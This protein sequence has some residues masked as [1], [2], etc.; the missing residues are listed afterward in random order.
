MDE[1]VFLIII[2][3]IVIVSVPIIIL[4]KISNIN[5]NID[6]LNKEINDLNKKLVDISNKAVTKDETKEILNTVK[7]IND[8]I[9]VSAPITQLAHLK[10]QS[11]PIDFLKSSK[12][13]KV[14][15]APT[16][17]SEITLDPIIEEIRVDKT[18]V[19]DMPV[20][21]IEL[22]E[23]KEKLEPL[24][25][26]AAFKRTEL[27]KKETIYTETPPPY[28]SQPKAAVQSTQKE[29]DGRNFIERILGE[30][31]LS[32][33]GIITLVLGIAFF[34]KYAIDQEWINEVGRVGIGLLTGGIL[35]GIAHKLK[36]KYHV[37]SSLLVGGGISTFYITITLAFREYELFS[38]T[39]AFAILI[40]I[41]VFSVIL[42]LL[43]DRKE[44]AI[45]SLLGG[46]ASPLMIST[47]TGNYIV[48]FS[49][50]LILNTGM[51][52]VSFRKKWPII[53]II[54]YVLTLIFFWSWILRSYE[55]QYFEVT[56]FAVLF[57]VQFYLL[58]LIDHFKQEKKITTYQAILILTNNLSLFLAWIYIFNEYPYDV[59]G[60][61]TISIAAVN[62]IVM[63][64]LFRKS[65]IDRN[66]IYLIIAVVMTFVSLAIPIQLQGY[67]ITMFWAAEAVLL[68]WLWQKSQIKVFQIGFLLVSALVIVSYIID[69]QRNYGDKDD[70]SI[71]LNSIFITGLVVIGGFVINS[72]L[73]KRE[74]KD[75][76]IKIHNIEFFSLD[77]VIYIFKALLIISVFIVPFIELNYQLER[78]TDTEYSSSFRYVS[79]A[80]YSFT[81]IIT[82]IFIHR[83]K[84]SS[85]MMYLTLLTFV[86]GA[87]SLIFSSLAT[88]LRF[89]VFCLNEYTASYF[90]VHLISLPAIVFAI[91]QIIKNIK[92]LPPQMFQAF[93]WATVIF[94][95]IILSVETDNFIILLLGHSENYSDILYDVHTFGYPIL[96]GVIAMILMIWG[97][98]QREV[99]LR[100][101]SLIFFGLII[102][103][104]YAYDV[105]H[106]SQA[107]RIISF[108]L[109]GV[110]L[111]LVSFLQQKIKIL[112][113]DEN[114]PEGINKEE[115]TIE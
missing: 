68:L 87:Y 23:T 19:E 91:Y 48:L 34:V 2:V 84:I 89:D 16:I 100:K 76:I 92:Q 113:K 43:Y 65:T 12:T 3:L 31:W 104:F 72:F 11:E 64:I 88:D 107:G 115:N 86:V 85:K 109:L 103:K 49:Y 111:L 98:K 39:I 63:L 35:I 71:A 36:S 10:E 41:T 30:N 110:I 29:D 101:I 106:M 80:V 56:L 37:F 9:Q 5:K 81:Y 40:M 83:E 55:A 21:A 1:I 82:V 61:I 97:L 20:K 25:P 38:Q 58:A 69:I 7:D 50:I 96:W 42:S 28:Y 4:V 33:V 46:F 17:T 45:F 70:L 15:D 24:R 14:E 18:T 62:A 52:L 74:D 54:S 59:R 78:F 27:D 105:W 102:L 53:G 67:V 94:S 112:V 93:C 26:V 73:L 99:L 8:K 66:L 77:T 51:L 6:Y 108:V 44:L 57:F 60:I 13:E 95:V 79:L 47:G 90:L 22:P 75:S 32:K 114:A